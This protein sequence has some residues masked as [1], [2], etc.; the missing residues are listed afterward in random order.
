MRVD[1]GERNNM[2]ADHPEVVDRLKNLLIKYI[3]EGRSTPG[4]PQRNDGPYPWK[5][6]DWM[7]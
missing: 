5:Q 1:P 2:E 6:L 3:K 4:V 7:E